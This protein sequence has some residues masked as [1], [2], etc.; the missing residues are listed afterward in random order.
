MPPNGRSA[1]S[2]LCG[3]DLFLELSVAVIVLPDTP[4]DGP[5]RALPPLLAVR[6]LLVVQAAQ[7][8]IAGTTA[9]DRLK[10]AAVQEGERLRVVLSRL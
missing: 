8:G 6:L 4:E 1:G 5:L 10:V 7:H 3:T 2:A 9:Q